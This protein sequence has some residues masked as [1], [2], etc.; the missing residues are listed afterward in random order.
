MSE[1]EPACGKCLIKNDEKA[2]HTKGGKAPKFCPTKNMK[3]VIEKATDAY[4]ASD[5]I[6][7][8][9]RQ[10]SIQEA[11]C[12]ANRDKKPSIL[13]PVKPRL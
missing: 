7:E 6:L 9:A 1:Y 5:E 13:H 3:D 12:Y 10:A 8:F 4:F 11:E 2:C